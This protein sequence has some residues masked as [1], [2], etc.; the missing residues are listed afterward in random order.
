MDPDEI[1]AFLDTAKTAAL[2]SLGRDGFPHTVAMWF[3]P[4]GD[5]VLM[6]TY[7]KSQKARNLALD[8]RCS[9]MA[10]TGEGYVELK[11]ILVKARAR[12]VADPAEVESI[13][14][15]L[16]D[17]YTLPRTGIPVEDGPIVEV[18][19]Q[20]AKRIGI[21]VPFENVASWDHSKLG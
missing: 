2:T 17:R 1:A 20:A 13:G 21:A 3:I 6:W 18:Q 16:Y 12:L 19:K 4:D 8:R 15:R 14:K 5:H 11:G 9:F 7:A 10:E